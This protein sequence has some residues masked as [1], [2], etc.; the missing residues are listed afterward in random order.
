MVGSKERRADYDA[1]LNSKDSTETAPDTLVDL[2]EFVDRKHGLHQHYDTRL[3]D[4]VR[5][6]MSCVP[7]KKTV[8]IVLS[9]GDK[10]FTENDLGRLDRD[11]LGKHFSEDAVDAIFNSKQNMH[12]L[13][14]VVKKVLA[15]ILSR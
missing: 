6:I 13:P 2:L 9:V 7:P 12:G 15:E 3:H 14:D 8:V 11:S 1:I 5:S 4:P 10:H